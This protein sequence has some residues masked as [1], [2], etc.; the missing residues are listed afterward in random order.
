MAL[1]HEEDGSMSRKRHRAEE[2]VAKLRQVEV[3]TAQGQSVA[4]AIR[5]IGVTEVSSGTSCS[6]A[7]S[8]PRSRRPRSSSRAGV[9]TTIAHQNAHLAMLLVRRGFAAQGS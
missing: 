4:E 8:S 7:R 6:T 5:S 2:I 1:S 3:L 9:T